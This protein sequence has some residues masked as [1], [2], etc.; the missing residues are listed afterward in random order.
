MS[1]VSPSLEAEVRDLREEMEDLCSEVV[2]LRRAV[3]EFRHER[4]S[5]RS[6]DSRSDSRGG[7]FPPS[8]STHTS[9]R[10]SPEPGREEIPLASRL[11]IIVRD[12]S[13][14][15]YTPVKVM[16]SCKLLVKP[17]GVDLGDSM[18]GCPQ[19]EKP[20]VSSTPRSWSGL[21]SWDN[22]LVPPGPVTS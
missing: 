9:E 16:R 2:H 14:L 18:F 22:E 8:P 21:K 7:N 3:R 12:H 19:R 1:H 20:V 5:R 4:D 6:V 10:P 13:G 17:R 15:I 11:W